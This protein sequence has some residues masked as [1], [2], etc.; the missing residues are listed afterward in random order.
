MG[1]VGSEALQSSPCP[2]AGFLSLLSKEGAVS[3]AAPRC[4]WGALQSGGGHGLP[5]EL[6]EHPRLLQ[7]S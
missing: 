3:R 4:H 2:Q 5:A 1:G 6:L 7:S